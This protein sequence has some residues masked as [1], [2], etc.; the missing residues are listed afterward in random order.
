MN[1]GSGFSEDTHAYFD[2]DRPDAAERDRHA[3][4]QFAQATAAFVQ[5]EA[6]P[7]REVDRAV[8]A[9]IRAE[10]RQSAWR[11]F[12]QPQVF[13]LRPVLAAAAIFV[14]AV[15]ISMF[16][17]GSAADPDGAGNA[18]TTVLVRFELRAPGASA[19]ALA[20][21]FNSWD[22]EAVPLVR[23]SAEDLWT[24]TVPLTPGE[25]QY[26]FVIDGEEW[27]PDPHAHAQVDDGFGQRN[28]VIIVAPRGVVRS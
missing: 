1:R 10:R 9:V 17:G 23:G 3:A 2:G 8:M 6:V 12:I 16:G 13:R 11:W 7:G 14:A 28:S 4:D 19:V 15:G 24:V 27:I 21:S 25:H 26:L 22:D 20:G 5:G 18:L